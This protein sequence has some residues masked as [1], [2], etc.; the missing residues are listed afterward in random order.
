MGIKL[1]ICIPTYNR[2]GNLSE[3]LDALA[4]MIG[5]ARDIE[6]I[7]SDNAS[8]DGTKEYMKN[9]ETSGKFKNLHYHRNDENIGPDNNF[10]MCYKLAKGDYTWLVGDDDIIMGDIVPY[11]MEVIEKYSPGVVYIGFGSEAEN[12]SEKS[13]ISMDDQVVVCNDYVDFMLKVDYLFLISAFICKQE[14]IASIDFS[15]YAQC[16]ELKYALAILKCAYESATNVVVAGKNY[17][18]AKMSVNTWDRYETMREW[19]L[20]N[21]ICYEEEKKLYYWFVR[22]II[23]QHALSTFFALSILFCRENM[24]EISLKWKKS[25]ALDTLEN[26]YPIYKAGYK[27]L[28][29]CLLDEISTSQ[30]VQIFQKIKKESIVN[31]AKKLKRIYI[32]GAGYWGKYYKQLLDNNGVNI[33]GFLVSDY[34]EITGENIYHL[35]E[36]L[37]KEPEEGVLVAVQ[38]GRKMFDILRSLLASEWKNRMDY[39]VFID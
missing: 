38:Y 32:Y 24:P 33:N 26:H 13:E 18:K 30:A 10:V 22:K 8:T 31:F 27:W 21:S 34:K 37:P 19:V 29:E 20:V 2:K 11:L 15:K 4:E 9:L 16:K 25:I 23:Y 12:V 35:S 3:L 39:I 14:I 7:I 36:V 1:S 17:L 28:M 6:V 5:E